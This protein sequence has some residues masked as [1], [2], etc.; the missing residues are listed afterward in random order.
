M[1]DEQ[2]SE[3]VRFFQEFLDEDYGHNEYKSKIQNLKD[4]RLIIDL[5]HVRS[6][7]KEYCQGLL[8][9]PSEYIPA[10]DKAFK[11]V[12]TATRNVEDLEYKVGFE[13]AFGDYQ[14]TPRNLSARYLGKML[15]LDGIVTR[16]S[17]VRPKVAKSVHYSETTK[18][19]HYKEYKDG[20]SLGSNVSTGGFY[21]KEDENGNMLSTEYGY[22]TYRDSQTISIQEMP[23]R[24]PAGELPRPVDIIL[25]NDLVDKVKSGDRV[26]IVGVYRTVGKNSIT[27][28]T[29]RTVFLANNISLLGKE[30][31][32]PQIHESDAREIRKI[33][34]RKDV[35]KLV[36]SS[37]APSIYGHEYIKKAL[38]LLMLGGI[39]KN[40]ENGTHLR[41]DINI[42]LI[43]DPSV[44][45][46]QMLRF[47][48]NLAPLAIA[49]T[50]RG[51]SGVGLTA[52][53]TMDKE[54]GERTLEAGAM[55]L[56]DRG[57]VCIDEFDKMSDIDRVAIHEVMEQQ[58]VTI[59]KAGIHTSLNARC[60]VLAA[61]NPAFGSYLDEKKPFENIVLP[62]SL[63]S[64]F[65]L[66]FVVLDKTDDEFNRAIADHVTRLH[67]YVPPG[68]EEGE[69]VT[70]E[71][72]QSLD[73]VRLSQ[74]ETV[75][76][77]Y[78]PLLHIGLRPKKK[79]Q[80][81]LLSIGFLKKY[82]YY[83]KS[84]VKPV[85][86]QE[87]SDYI[88]QRYAELRSKNDGQDQQYRTMPITPRTLETL[89]RLST[90]HAKLRLSKTVEE[91]DA[92][93]A[94]EILVYALFKEVKQK[95]KSK[96]AKTGNESES[97]SDAETEVTHTT[98]PQ[99]TVT[100][101]T[102]S[103]MSALVDAMEV[104]SSAPSQSSSTNM[105]AF[106]RKLFQ[107]KQNVKEAIQRMSS[108][109]QGVWYQEDTE[110]VF[111]M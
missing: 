85:L 9:D 43:G 111:F 35:L 98:V 15:C 44:G 53:V 49:T 77:K 30:I 59:A 40:L 79:K 50:G 5:N 84:R 45:K 81:E 46:S 62:D 60:S 74:E 11:D 22:S 95:K 69:P 105:E 14:L 106:Q 63:L 67:R 110:A 102:S 36:S 19:F 55:V 20:T 83:C 17:L 1:Q 82:I 26:R 61:A 47:V 88:S 29:F 13:G 31:S 2:F 107:I 109:N 48:L 101:A 76:Q 21:P 58:T 66:V 51:S 71:F 52:A 87:A 68:L 103:R 38:L 24:A 34:K 96:K 91:M 78:N 37:L 6:Y 42:L 16:C 89:I 99:T 70:E 86:S 100:G 90:A 75:Y 18:L 3:R 56:A 32:Q 92:H 41:G 64:R 33:S 23:E 12:I 80:I 73:Q 57:V 27:S 28:A 8:E 39:E 108:E 25:D 93:V 7:N 10:F 97:E 94:F 4:T 104:D 72:I 65:D 54:T